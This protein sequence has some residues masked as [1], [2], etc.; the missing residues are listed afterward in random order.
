MPS[1]ALPLSAVPPV[2]LSMR[3]SPEMVSVPA[4]MPSPASLRLLL[5]S[6]S[7]P[8]ALTMWALP[9]MVRSPSLW[10]PLPPS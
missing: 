6:P 8:V 2:A 9:E 4:R 5:L 1:P 10:M 3:A 7:P